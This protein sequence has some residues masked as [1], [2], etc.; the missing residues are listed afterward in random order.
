M[1]ALIVFSAILL[2][3]QADAEGL[4]VSGEVE[5][6]RSQYVIS[7]LTNSWRTQI[8][9][10]AEEGQRVEPGDLVMQVD[11]AGIETQQ[12][13]AEDELARFEATAKRDIANLQLAMNNAELD[14]ARSQIQLRIAS[15]KA[16]VP[17]D[18]IGELEYQENQL[19]LEQADRD[20]SKATETY[21]NADTRL[22]EKQSEVELERQHRQQRLEL[23]DQMLEAV[24]IRA[25]QPG[26]VLHRQH[27]WSGVKYQ[28]GD[29]VQTSW[30][31]AAVADDQDL[32]VVAWINAIDLPRLA[33]DQRVEI[34]F[35]ALP[36]QQITG[37]LLD[38]PQA[39]QNKPQWGKGLYHKA[40]VE[41]EPNALPLLPGMSALVVFEGASI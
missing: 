16:E 15:M 12:R 39:G 14:L 34:Q 6:R 9:F 3:T 4:L 10:L 1:R 31:I 8:T 20:V 23:W 19:A 26:F 28:T 32:Q 35:D 27:P 5:S 21:G 30:E 29:Q 11:G 18:F 24:Q 22:T 25:Q 38:I 13:S 37:R 17:A 40:I 41:I 2:A 36:N 33:N 7:P